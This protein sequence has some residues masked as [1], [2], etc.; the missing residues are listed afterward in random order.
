MRKS[1]VSLILTGI[2]CGLNA[3]TASDLNEGSQVVPS[4]TPD[5]YLFSWW[6]KQDRFYVI[7]HST[8]L[9]APWAHIPV[10]EPGYD[11]IAQWGFATNA[12]KFFLRLKYTDEALTGSFTGDDDGDGIANGV[13]VLLG[14]SAI[15]ANGNSD[16]DLLTDREELALGLDPNDSSDAVDSDGDGI[17]DAIERLYGL[18]TSGTTDLDGDSMDDEWELKYYLDLTIDDSGLDPDGDG[19]TNLQEF[20]EGTNPWA[21]DTDGDTIPDGIEVS[22]GLDPLVADSVRTRN[23]YALQFSSDLE[24]TDNQFPDRVSENSGYSSSFEP[25]LAAI[26]RFGDVYALGENSHGQF[27][28]GTTGSIYTSPVLSGFSGVK[29]IAVGRGTFHAVKQNGTVSAAGAQYQGRLGNGQTS[30]ANIATPV[31]LA[32]FSGVSRIN[33]KNLQV[34]QAI[35]NGQIYIWGHNL[36][37]SGSF[38]YT[39]YSSSAQEPSPAGPKK[40]LSNLLSIGSDYGVASQ[41]QGVGLKQDGSVEMWGMNGYN[42]LTENAALNYQTPLNGS[43]TIAVSNIIQTA[44]NDGSVMALDKNGEVWTWGAFNGIDP[45]KTAAAQ[46]T[47]TNIETTI[48]A[49]AIVASYET[50][51]I[52]SSTVNAQ[53]GFWLGSDGLVRRIYWDRDFDITDGSFPENGDRRSIPISLPFKTVAIA[54]AF[55]GLFLLTEHGELYKYSHPLEGSVLEEIPI[56]DFY[57]GSDTDA[58]GV[59]DVLARFLGLNPSSL[60]T[61]G[62]GV[63]DAE[64]LALGIDPWAWDLDGDGIPNSVE[65]AIGLDPR[66]E[67]SDGDGMLDNEE[68][69]LKDRRS[70]YVLT[71]ESNGTGPSISLLTPASA[72]EL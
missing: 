5:N 26:D 71:N 24:D 27:G 13:E 34:W 32:G 8:D 60:D 28:I 22:N 42:S 36:V 20:N 59:S 3:Q 21:F 10:I 52:D 64:A 25:A 55:Q 7:Q 70:N 30:A 39:N 43:K 48:P 31:T 33:A 53:R 11:E 45:P 37:V 47:P 68:F 40:G 50:F 23:N 18:S 6:G 65:I 9:L 19:L 35:A 58:D 57:D 15:T 66:S 4:S 1:I 41:R 67:D 72:T 62:D 14:Y 44:V 38:Y 54:P 63:P 12:D 61:N 29:S 51:E 17:V 56:P 49:R 69:Y 46:R 16:G 2:T